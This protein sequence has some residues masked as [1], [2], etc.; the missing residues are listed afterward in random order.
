[1]LLKEMIDRKENIIDALT[2]LQEELEAQY[3]AGMNSEEKEDEYYILASELY[4]I[5]EAISYYRQ[6]A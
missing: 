2:E 5:N 6:T 3:A 4:T 1:M